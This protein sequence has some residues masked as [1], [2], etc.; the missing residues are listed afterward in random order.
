MQLRNE[1]QQS[2]TQLTAMEREFGAEANYVYKSHK[3][4]I[5]LVGPRRYFAA[6]HNSVTAGGVRIPRPPAFLGSEN[7]YLSTEGRIDNKHKNQTK[8]GLPSILP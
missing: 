4:V 3:K 8:Y 7:N 5:K 1:K 6:R 2:D